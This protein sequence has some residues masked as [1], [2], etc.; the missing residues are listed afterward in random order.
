MCDL[1]G[2]YFVIYVYKYLRYRNLD[3][4]LQDS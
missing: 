4:G 1:W 3:I 2:I